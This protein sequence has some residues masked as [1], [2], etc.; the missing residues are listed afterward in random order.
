MVGRPRTTPSHAFSRLLTPSHAFARLRTPSQVEADEITPDMPDKYDT[1]HIVNH[2]QSPSKLA[3]HAL[4]KGAMM[5]IDMIN[6]NLDRSTVEV[7]VLTA[8][9]KSQLVMKSVMKDIKFT[10]KVAAAQ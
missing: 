3:L 5:Y 9:G 1:I 7:Q 8:C 4:G 6:D 2:T 10:P